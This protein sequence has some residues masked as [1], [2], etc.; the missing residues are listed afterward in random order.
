[1]YFERTGQ[2]MTEV[3]K[4][5]KEKKMANL[6]KAAAKSQ[7]LLKPKLGAPG[8]S[9]RVKAKWQITSVPAFQTYSNVAHGF[10]GGKWIFFNG[11]KWSYRYMCGIQLPHTDQ[12]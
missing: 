2:A 12:A 9:F 10:L 3:L 5:K 1:M 6:S 4:K 8:S 7:G 11:V